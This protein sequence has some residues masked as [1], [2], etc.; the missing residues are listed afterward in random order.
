MPAIAKK[1][2]GTIIAAMGTFEGLVYVS[3]FFSQQI[4]FEV[5]FGEKKMPLIEG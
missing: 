2:I 3:Y 5:S 4:Y 1:A